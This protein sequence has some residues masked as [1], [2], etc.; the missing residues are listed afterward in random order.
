[1]T[2]SDDRTGDRA[3]APRPLEGVRVVDLTTV[4]AGPY[5]SLLLADLGADVVKIEAPGGDVARDL[6][7]RVHDGMAAVFLN[8]NRGKRSVVLDLR[9]P[10]GRR[11]LK[12]LTDAADVFVH[13]MRP[14]AAARC[15]ADPATLREGNE[16]LVYCA[17]H[18][19]RADGSYADLATYDDIIQAASGVGG[20]Q[21]W[22]HGAPTY[23][24][25]AV[26]DK[27]SGL[28]G[29]LAITAALRRQAVHGTGAV[30]EVPMVETLTAFGVLEHLW[31]RTFVPPRGSARYPRM[32]SRD[33]RPYRTADG[34]LAVM[35]YTD[36]N[37][38]RFFAL[39]GRP[40]LAGEERFATLHART[41]H[42]DELLPIVA[43][44]LASGTTEEWF[45]RLR[46]AGI[47]AVPYNRVDDLFDDEHLDEVG[48][49]EEFEH[50]TEG[51]LLQCR[52]PITFDGEKP[53]LGAAA[54]T[55][56]ADTVAV[57]DELPP[58]A[59]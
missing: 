11:T 50:P 58:D 54:P 31:G 56:G 51:T 16:R 25:T 33:R 5:A 10:D 28:S 39:V 9:T 59:G 22:L 48:F 1:V 43:D 24:A 7:P 29:A 6:G 40:E 35:V 26:G 14:A 4:V 13:N 21:E 46:D 52:L 34:W 23:M 55:L 8:F 3:T 36:E 18:G 41:A 32:S 2:P 19:Y 15:G 12:R 20:Q 53:P 38:R 42:L 49:W 27:V 47:P 30:I 45:G 37:W 57:L 44:A 17:M